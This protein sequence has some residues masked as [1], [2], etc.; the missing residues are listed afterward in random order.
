MGTVARLTQ[1]AWQ[2]R[3]EGFLGLHFPQHKLQ[4]HS[5]ASYCKC[6]TFGEKETEAAVAGESEQVRITSRSRRRITSLC[7]CSIEL[8]IPSASPGDDLL[9]LQEN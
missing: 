3:V 5:P 6:K 1:A 7:S 8:K 4:S 2:E 9:V